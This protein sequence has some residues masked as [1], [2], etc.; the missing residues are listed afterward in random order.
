MEEMLGVIDD[1]RLVLVTELWIC[2]Q[3]TV[4]L[5][6]GVKWWTCCHLRNVLHTPS[7]W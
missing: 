3:E 7:E 1:V 4:E 6:V 5:R 2:G